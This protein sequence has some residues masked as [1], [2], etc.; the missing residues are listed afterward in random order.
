MP[1]VVVQDRAEGAIVDEQ[2]SV[3]FAKQVETE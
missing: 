3:A 2:R 1:S